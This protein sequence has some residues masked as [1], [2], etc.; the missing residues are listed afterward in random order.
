MKPNY[1]ITGREARCL[2]KVWFAFLLFAAAVT[3]L[4]DRF[5]KIARWR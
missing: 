4:W 5:I 3:W 1:A 2:I